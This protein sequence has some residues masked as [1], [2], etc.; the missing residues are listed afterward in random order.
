MYT[1]ILKINETFRFLLKLIKNSFNFCNI[2]LAFIY[3]TQYLQILKTTK[4]ISLILLLFIT[5]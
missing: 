3:L 2:K 4:F 5:I 1:A